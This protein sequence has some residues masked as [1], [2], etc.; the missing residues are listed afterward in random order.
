MIARLEKYR[1]KYNQFIRGLLFHNDFFIVLK[2]IPT[3]VN[4]L[5]K[6]SVK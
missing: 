3:I 1:K 6:K 5:N 2:N 4:K